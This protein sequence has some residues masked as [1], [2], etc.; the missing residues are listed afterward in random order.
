LQPRSS[1]RRAALRRA[2][3]LEQEVTLAYLRELASH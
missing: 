2:H 3:L 1:A